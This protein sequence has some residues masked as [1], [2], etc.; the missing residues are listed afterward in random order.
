MAAGGVGVWSC[1][2][3]RMISLK[4]LCI[5]GVADGPMGV[6]SGAWAPAARASGGAT[7]GTNARRHAPCRCPVSFYRSCSAAGCPRPDPQSA[8]TD[9]IPP[10]LPFRGLR[11]DPSRSTSTMRSRPSSRA[12]RR[13]CACRNWNSRIA[14]TSSNGGPGHQAC[15]TGQAP[16][17]PTATSTGARSGTIPGMRRWWT[18]D[19]R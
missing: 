9:G 19:S 4:E 1:T 10:V 12:P 2:A 3:T 14:P 13:G 6:A 8:G 11:R 5:P 18:W 7:L 15:D 17:R 16:T